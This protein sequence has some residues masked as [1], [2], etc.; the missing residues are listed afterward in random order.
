[1]YVYYI[2]PSRS[3]TYAQVGPGGMCNCTWTAT[4]RGSRQRRHIRN[5]GLD[6]L[7]DLEQFQRVSVTIKALRVDAPQQIPTGKMKQ[8]V[9][10]GDSTGTTRLTLWE[11]EIGS[12]DEDSSY[13][14]KSDYSTIPW[15]VIS[16]HLQRHILHY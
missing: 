14:L 12:M 10:I 2:C 8:D 6:Q 4:T 5:H 13:Q 9:I 7:P 15:K 16:L 1:M 3:S 11:E